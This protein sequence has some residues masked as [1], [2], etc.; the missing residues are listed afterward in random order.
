MKAC[1]LQLQLQPH[2]LLDGSKKI[3]LGCMGALLVVIFAIKKGKVVTSDLLNF[4]C[5]C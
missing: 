5:T 1:A 3:K 2:S 4:D